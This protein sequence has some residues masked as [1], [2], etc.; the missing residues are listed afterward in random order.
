MLG[1]YVLTHIPISKKV[2][3]EDAASTG[4]A[5]EGK[6]KQRSRKYQRQAAKRDAIVND[7]PTIPPL[8]KIPAAEKGPDL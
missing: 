4:A 7:D 5:K 3:P 2:N 8:A 1:T 6:Q